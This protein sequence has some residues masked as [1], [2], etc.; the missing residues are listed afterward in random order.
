MLHFMYTFDLFCLYQP[1]NE[2]HFPWSISSNMM[3]NMMI[4]SVTEMW[5]NIIIS[6][7]VTVQFSLHC[8]CWVYIMHISHISLVWVDIVLFWQQGHKVF[9]FVKASRDVVYSLYLWKMQ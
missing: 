9:M 3:I 5:E 2:L 7:P 1:V 4:W 8:I 6:K